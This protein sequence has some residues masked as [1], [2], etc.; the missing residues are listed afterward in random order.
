MSINTN[1]LASIYEM[2]GHKEEAMVIY[3]E[4]LHKDP[5]NK[6]AHT[7]LMRKKKQ[8]HNFSVSNHDKLELFINATTQKE[9][10]KLEQW[11]LSW[12]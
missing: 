10:Q 6:Q 3:E 2:Q 5:K 1:M 4:I 9:Y 11:L 7:A 8:K 12:E